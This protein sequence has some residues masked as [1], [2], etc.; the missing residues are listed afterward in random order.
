MFTK[1]LMWTSCR[2]DNSIKNKKL[3]LKIQIWNLKASGIGTMGLVNKIQIRTI[4]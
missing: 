4:K 2:N 1:K 3:N